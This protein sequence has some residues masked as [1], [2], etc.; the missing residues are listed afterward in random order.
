MGEGGGGGGQGI[1]GWYLCLHYRCTCGWCV[2]MCINKSGECVYICVDGLYVCGEVAGG[3]DD[4]AM[5]I[6][7]FVKKKP[8][9]VV[10]DYKN[11]MLRQFCGLYMYVSL[12]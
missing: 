5:Q 11:L 2:C 8:Q 9:G 3:L 12:N 7:G 6:Q 4:S 1:E 10:T